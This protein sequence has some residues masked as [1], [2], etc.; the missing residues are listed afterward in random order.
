MK[1]VSSRSLSNPINLLLV[2]LTLLIISTLLFI[3]RWLPI[4]SLASYFD[5]G[6]F[7]ERAEFILSGNLGQMS[8][9]YNALVKG[10][11]YPWFVVISSKLDLNPIFFTYLILILIVIFMCF[12]LFFITKN[13]FISLILGIILLADPVFFSESSSRL[14]REITQQNFVYLFFILF[15]LIIYLIY[16]KVF[17]PYLLFS[18]SLICGLL[19][20]LSINIREENIWIFSALGLNIL[21]FLIYR[22]RTL[23]IL[24]FSA[25]IILSM[26]ISIQIVKQANESFYGVPLLNSTTQGEFPKMM[27]L[28][29]GIQSSAGN[30]RYVSIDK[31]KRYL[32]YEVSPTFSKLK[33]NLEGPGLAWIQ[34]GCQDSQTCDDYANGWFHVALREAMKGVGWWETEQLAQQKMRVINSEIGNACLNQTIE[35]SRGIPFGPA[36]GNQFISKIELVDSIGFFR[37]YI[38]S[39]FNNWGISRTV[40]GS[41]LFK[42]SVM[43][44]NFYSSWHQIIPSMPASQKDYID[45]FNSRYLSFQPYL[46]N[47]SLFYSY[48]LKIMLIG[49]I[50]LVI[51]FAFKKIKT[52]RFLKTAYIVS[53]YLW[54]SKGILLSLN[55]SINFKSINLTYA[56]GARVFLTTFLCLGV[57]MLFNNSLNKS[58][59]VNVDS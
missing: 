57:I 37:E 52:H 18:S 38:V 32:A 3:R 22:Y 31:E 4:N 53:F 26:L 46:N 24:Q 2:F 58:S 51:L 12:V 40:D 27:T 16:T 10:T 36:Y 49:N 47:W 15:N 54:I 39:S 5:D 7:L 1:T 17:S 44:E 8:N 20:T 29:S 9:G 50:L 43:P 34:Y 21:I 59:E 33:P 19:L 11:F 41:T 30:K 56:L 48:L 45:K 55:S 6:L 23:K 25:L 14:V 42:T 13:V 28:L 35:C